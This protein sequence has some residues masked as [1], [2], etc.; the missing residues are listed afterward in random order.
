MENNTTSNQ[1]G[2][3]SEFKS[4]GINLIGIS[5]IITFYIFILMVG[6]WAGRKTKTGAGHD[7]EEVML[8][9]RNIGL[10]VGVFT[11]TGNVTIVSRYYREILINQKTKTK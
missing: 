2:I 4:P 9:G 11:M 8:A 6:I 10:W 1:T 5:S 7:E 3:P